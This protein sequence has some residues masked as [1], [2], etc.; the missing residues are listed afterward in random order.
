[1]TTTFLAF[2]ILG[3]CA[4]GNCQPHIQPPIQQPAQ[5]W[6]FL[7]KLEALRGEVQGVTSDEILA[8]NADERKVYYEN[9]RKMLR[10]ERELRILIVRQ[11]K[12]YYAQAET[13]ARKQRLSYRRAVGYTWEAGQNIAILQGAAQI[14]ATRRFFRSNSFGGSNYYGGGYPRANSFGGSNYYG[15]GY[16]SLGL[17]L[18][19]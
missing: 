8:M 7:D 2:V 17:G 15:G 12:T 16:P 11:R 5:N 18:S 4:G 6:V 14:E 3:Q 13:A 19:R 1:M 10:M 9:K